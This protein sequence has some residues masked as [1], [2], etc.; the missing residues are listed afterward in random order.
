MPLEKTVTDK[1]G[2]FS[3][4]NYICTISVEKPLSRVGMVTFFYACQGTKHTEGI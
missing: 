2:P 1:Y 4:L 3:N